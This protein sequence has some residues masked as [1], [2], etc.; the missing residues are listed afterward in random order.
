M[1]QHREH[2]HSAREQR[3]SKHPHQTSGCNDD[4]LFF[5]Q[6]RDSSLIRR[7]LFPIACVRRGR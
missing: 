4:G 3:G 7:D 5:A 1:G 6:R 2:L